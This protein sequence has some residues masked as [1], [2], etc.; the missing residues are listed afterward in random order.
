MSTI[1][2]SK[3]QRSGFRLGWSQ[4][5]IS[6][7]NLFTKLS[8]ASLSSDELLVTFQQQDSVTALVFHRRPKS[9]SLASRRFTVKNFL[10][11]LNPEMKLLSGD[12]DS[13]GIKS[14][15]MMIIETLM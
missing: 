5:I 1:N 10:T 9:N 13:S 6:L 7:F 14:F 4:I 3:A 8:R 15:V 2:M 12:F 11:H